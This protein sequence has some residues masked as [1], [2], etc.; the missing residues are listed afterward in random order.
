MATFN[1][2][3][4]VQKLIDEQ[5]ALNAVRDDIFSLHEIK[6]YAREQGVSLNQLR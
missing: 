4:T 1:Q 6:A 2:I 5:A 3:K